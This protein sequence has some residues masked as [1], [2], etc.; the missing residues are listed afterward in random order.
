MPHLLELFSGTQS[1]GKVAK[2]LGYDVISLDICDYKGK[3]PVTHKID[4]MEF[5]YKQYSPDK[6]TTIW[7]SPPCLYYSQLQ[8]SWYGRMKKSGL[9]TK[10]KHMSEMLISDKW[11]KKVLEIINYFNCEKWVIENPRTGKLRTREFMKDIQFVDVDYCRYSDWGYKKA[12]RLW[13]NIKFKGKLCNKTCGNMEGKKH[14][15]ECSRDIWTT[16]MRYRVPPKLI[17]EVLNI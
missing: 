2:S 16:L 6:F 7:A 14:K 15:R 11:V 4:I 9:Y 13:T 17:E 3:Y 10:E 5:D 12:T 8:T 1:V